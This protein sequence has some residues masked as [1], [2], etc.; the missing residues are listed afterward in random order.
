VNERDFPTGIEM[1]VRIFV[2]HFSV[3]CPAGVT[4]AKR[5]W[6][7]LFRHQFGERGDSP[8]T[9]TCLDVITIDNRD[10]G[11]VVTPIFEATQAIE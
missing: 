10:S 3:S 9:F 4:D 7:G 5:A 6:R 1:R 11:R 8:G 2:V